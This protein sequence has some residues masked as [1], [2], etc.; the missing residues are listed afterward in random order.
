M[1]ALRCWTIEQDDRRAT[2]TIQESRLVDTMVITINDRTDES[3]IHL[4]REAWEAL[5]RATFDFRWAYTAPEYLPQA[6]VFRPCVE[7]QLLP[8]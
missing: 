5:M 3:S 6:P 4:S 1:N 7:D 2:I 8:A